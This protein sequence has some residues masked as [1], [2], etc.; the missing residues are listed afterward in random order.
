MKGKE[1][2]GFWLF[3]FFLAL[4]GALHT[5]DLIVP[6]PLWTAILFLLYTT[7]Y[8]NLFIL[9][10]SSVRRRLLPTQARK[11]ALSSVPIMLWGSID[12]TLRF[13]VVVSPALSRFLWYCYYIPYVFLPLLFFLT[14][15]HIGPRDEYSGKKQD[16]LMFIP[17][18]LLVAGV[19]TNDLHYL[20]FRPREGVLFSSNVSHYSYGPLYMMVL[21]WIVLMCA[22]GFFHLARARRLFHSWKVYLGPLAFLGS[23]VLY[24]MSQ[25]Y[26]PFYMIG[27]YS[28]YRPMDIFCFSMLCLWES[29]IRNRLI[30]YNE[31]YLTLFPGMTLPIAVTDRQFHPQYRTASPIEASREAMRLSL[32]SPVLLHENTRL[33][34]KTIGKGYAFWTE[35]LTEINHTNEQLKEA[36]Q[37]LAEENDLIHAENALREKRAL[38]ESRS[39][40]YHDI[41]LALYPWQR[42]IQEILSSARPGSPD[43]PSQLTRAAILNAYVK[44]RTNLML[45]GADKEKINASELQLSFQESVRYLNLHGVHSSIQGE[46]TGML[47][48]QTALNAYD[49]F[50]KLIEALLGDLS[51]LLIF[52]SDDR[53]RLTMEGNAPLPAPPLSLPVSVWVEREDDILYVTLPIG[54]GGEAI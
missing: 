42:R 28:P 47:D 40:I 37:M 31:N 15:R 54:K 51:Q 10:G 20:A 32:S 38:I 53:V 30:P 1:Y 4:G 3:L 21:V 44:R 5:V 22:A 16:Q 35:D 33:S 17:A 26:P 19:L 48:K 18:I 29:C 45:L 27:Q 50:E 23:N 41:S 24:Y 2:K 34:G 12:Q 7:I 43:F 39:S 49:A 36:N 11:Y 13:R 14:C 52:L 46:M 9:W 8:G 25:F 6:G